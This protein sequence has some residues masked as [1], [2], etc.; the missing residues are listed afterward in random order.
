MQKERRVQTTFCMLTACGVHISGSCMKELL[1]VANHIRNDLWWL[2]WWGKLQQ[3]DSIRTRTTAS[4]VSPDPPTNISSSFSAFCIM[5]R[6]QIVPT[7]T[8]HVSFVLG[9]C[10]LC[11]QASFLTLLHSNL[12][13]TV[14]DQLLRDTFE[15]YGTIS[16]IVNP[17]FGY[18]PGP[19]TTNTTSN[20]SSSK[21]AV[22]SALGTSF[23]Q[24]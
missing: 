9:I 17:P 15:E 2:W 21:A 24:Q 6:T 11:N 16:E 4:P 7:S 5:A 19:C 8:L 10:L 1:R 20:R 22:P 18:T 23:S 3:V 14:T 13:D 12:S